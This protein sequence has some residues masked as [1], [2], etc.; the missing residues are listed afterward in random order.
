MNQLCEKWGVGQH[1]IDKTASKFFNDYKRLSKVTEE[2]EQ[3]I[4]KLQ[5]K[6]ILKD[7]DLKNCYVK[8]DQP[9]PTLYISWL[10]QYAQEFKDRGK[11]IVFIGGSFVVGLVGDPAG[12]TLVDLKK[13]AAEMSSKETKCVEMDKVSFAFKEKGKKKID[14]KG[15]KWF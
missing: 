1:D 7:P 10:K 14:A 6:S 15:V 13:V 5:V 3:Q 11:G 9:N 12:L 2:Q 8:S 4:L